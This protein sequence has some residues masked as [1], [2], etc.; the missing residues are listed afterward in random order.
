MPIILINMKYSAFKILIDFASNL[1]GNQQSLRFY[2]V[3]KILVIHY[4]F[5]EIN[6]QQHK[7]MSFYPYI[8][9]S[10]VRAPSYKSTHRYP[11]LHIHASQ[12]TDDLMS[13]FLLRKPYVG[14]EQ[15]MEAKFPASHYRIST[16]HD[17]LPIFYPSVNL[18]LTHSSPANL[19]YIHI[20]IFSNESHLKL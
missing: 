3:D 7:I 17:L 11:C 6:L 12:P 15:L 4:E 18:L 13:S 5:I 14:N 1:I 9:F 10:S 19:S 2:F 20:H 16:I 8:P